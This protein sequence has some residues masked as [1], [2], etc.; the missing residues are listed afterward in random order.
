MVFG[1]MIKNFGYT[2]STRCSIYSKAL[3][4]KYRW[5]ERGKSDI[6]VTILG[7]RVGKLDLISDNLILTWFDYFWNV[8]QCYNVNLC[9]KVHHVDFSDI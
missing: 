8:S 7:Y 3:L 6:T 9:L 1:V 5:K 2:F 4:A